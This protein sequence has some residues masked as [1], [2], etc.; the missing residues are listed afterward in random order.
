[1]SIDDKI[2]SEIL[3]SISLEGA[4]DSNEVKVIIASRSQG[5]ALLSFAT[6]LPK[7]SK[8]GDFSLSLNK[9][10]LL[11]SLHPFNFRCCLCGSIVSFPV[12]YFHQRFAVTSLHYFVCFN[13]TKAV[14]AKCYR[15]E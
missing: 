2:K 15:K 6:G 3:T 7:I 13:G 10:I 14:N 12:W 11:S 8:P 1:M 4:A 5:S 9:P